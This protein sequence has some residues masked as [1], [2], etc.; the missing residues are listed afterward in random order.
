MSGAI[1]QTGGERGLLP[2]Y[3]CGRAL[4]RGQSTEAGTHATSTRSLLAGALLAGAVA[5]GPGDADRIR[6]G[7]G[8]TG[9]RVTSVGCQATG[10]GEESGRMGACEEQTETEAANGNEHDGLRG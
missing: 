1:R 6:A 3:A 4:A 9:S 7:Q 5:S 2:L 8:V 10:R